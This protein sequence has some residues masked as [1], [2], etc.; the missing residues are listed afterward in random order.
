[1]MNGWNYEQEI[2][3]YNLKLLHLGK[4]AWPTF[5]TIKFNEGTLKVAERRWYK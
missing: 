3:R 5:G 4:R 2:R 1:M